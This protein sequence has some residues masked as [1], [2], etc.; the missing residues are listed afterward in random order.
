MENPFPRLSWLLEVTCIPWLVAPSP[1]LKLAA[2]GLVHFDSMSLPFLPLSS[3]FKDSCGYTEPFW[4]IQDNLLLKVFNL[5]TLAK[6][7]WSR[8]VACSQIPAPRSEDADL[9]HT[10]LW[11]FG[12]EV[13]RLWYQG[14]E[15]L[16]G[17]KHL[18]CLEE[19]RNPVCLLPSE[20]WEGGR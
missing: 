5:F 7:L 15:G 14:E 11:V 4:I 17:G 3:T 9:H 2:V 20:H 6:S 19:E 16:P 8:K 12:V 1:S 13:A 18:A 10:F